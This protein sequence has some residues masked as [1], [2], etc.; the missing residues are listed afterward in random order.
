M[1]CLL[2]C[3]TTRF[4]GRETS[5]PVL[6]GLTWVFHGSPGRSSAPAVDGELAV[7]DHH[8]RPRLFRGV[9]PGIALDRHGPE[10]LP[11]H[12]QGP[13]S[14]SSPD[15]TADVLVVAALGGQVADR[16]LLYPGHDQAQYDSGGT[17]KMGHDTFPKRRGLTRIKELMAA[18][19]NVS[20]GHD[21]VMDPWYS[22][23]T[24][25]MLEVASMALHV[26]QMAALDEISKTFDAVTVNGA[27]TLGLE[28]YG[29]EKGRRGDFVVLQAADPIWGASR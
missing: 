1:A 27:R 19:V 9:G 13:F 10:R 15:S 17:Q 3:L 23:G 14:A 12:P 11:G 20:F 25:D 7:F 2:I 24:H 18:G 4:A 21:C 8:R 29:L 22:L 5:R 28:S 6:A 26:A 16:Y